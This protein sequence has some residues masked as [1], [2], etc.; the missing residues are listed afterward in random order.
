MSRASAPSVPLNTVEKTLRMVLERN[1]LAHF[2]D[3]NAGRGSYFLNGVLKALTHL[4]PVEKALASRQ[5]RSRFVRF[6]MARF[7]DP[8]G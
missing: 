5:L 6:A 1:R 2:V 4:K 3:A 8:T 7:D